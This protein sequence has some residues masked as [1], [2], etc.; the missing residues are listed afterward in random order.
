MAQLSWLDDIAWIEHTRET[1]AFGNER[2]KMNALNTNTFEQ[3]NA[4]Q[5]NERIQKRTRSQKN[6]RIR[7]IN[8]FE[9]PLRSVNERIRKRTRSKN[10]RMRETNTLGNGCVWS[11]RV[12][13]SERVRGNEPIRKKDECV[14]E[15]LC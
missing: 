3:T 11:E 13:E 14:R 7:E 8:A 9:K 1:T 6:K 15:R 2:I 12:P 10:E 5:D 4:F